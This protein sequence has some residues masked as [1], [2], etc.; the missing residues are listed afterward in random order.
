MQII[1]ANNNFITN[2]ICSHLYSYLN[3]KC[4]IYDFNTR[5][6]YILLN[7]WWNHFNI[8][9]HANTHTYLLN[10]MC[11]KWKQLTCACIFF[12]PLYSLSLSLF[13]TCIPYFSTGF[14][15]MHCHYEWHLSI[16]MGLILQ[17][18]NISEM[19]PTPKGFPSCGN[20]LPELNE[21]QGFRAKNFYFM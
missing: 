1:K 15:L 5:T 21:L 14:W 4:K 7:I 20:Y 3:S 10:S 17:V 8:H 18:G 13:I 2:M 6:N 9:I 12:T 19:V 11:H 16:G